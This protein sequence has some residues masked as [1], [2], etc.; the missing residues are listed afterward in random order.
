MSKESGLDT[1]RDVDGLWS[2]YDIRDVAH[3]L[4]WSKDPAYVLEFY[5]MLRSNY[6]AVKPHAGHYALKSLEEFFEVTII[7]QNVDDLHEQAGSSQVIHLHGELFKSRSTADPNLVYEMK[8]DAINIGDLCE[9]GSQ[10]RPHIVW[11]A[12]E[13]ME[14]PRAVSIVQDAEMVIIAGT[15][16]SVY[17]A[18][19][20]LDVTPR[21]AKIY[22]VDPSKPQETFGRKIDYYSE[23]AASGLPKLVQNLIAAIQ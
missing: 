18:N 15:S 7:T 6:H 19:T 10:L 21:H 5:N 16:L 22:L 11:F 23:G 2:R 1:F 13:V 4:G 3:P 17:P 20:L 14:F 8:T 12:E 9:L